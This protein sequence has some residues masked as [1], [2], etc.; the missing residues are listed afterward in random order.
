MVMKLVTI[1]NRWVGSRKSFI[2][3]FIKCGCYLLRKC[4]TSRDFYF[5]AFYIEQNYVYATPKKAHEMEPYIHFQTTSYSTHHVRRLLTLFL[6][7][8]Y[9]CYILPLF[10]VVNFDFNI[11]FSE[12]MSLLLV[13]RILFLV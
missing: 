5:F 8:V 6:F 10:R 1:L 12:T 9:I 13:S 2:S 11:Y 7:C 4:N 3:Y